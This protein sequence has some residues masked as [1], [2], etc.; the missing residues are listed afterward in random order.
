VS[1]VRSLKVTLLRVVG[2]GAGAR[3]VEEKKSWKGFASKVPKAILVMVVVMFVV[4]GMRYLGWFRGFENSHLDALIRLWAA[5]K[6]S[7]NIAI[8]EINEQDYQ[9]RF[10]GTSPLDRRKL[11]DLIRAVQKY[12]PSVIGVDIDTNGWSTACKRHYGEDGSRCAREDADFGHA[13]G[14]LRAEA[15]KNGTVIVWA[16]V[17]RTPHPPLEL[18]PGLGSLPLDPDSDQLGIPGFPV[19]EDGSVRHFDGRVEVEKSDHGCPEGADADGG[20]CYLSSFARAI[21]EACAHKSTCGHNIGKTKTSVD[22]PVIFNFHGDRYQFPIIDATQFPE[23]VPNE[24]PAEQEIDSANTELETSRNARFAGKV[25]LIGGGYPEARDEYFT[26]RGLMQG[27]ELNALAIQTDLEGGGIPEVT[28]LWEILIDFAVGLYIVGIFYRFE[29]RPW[30]ALGWTAV[31]VPIAFVASMVLFRTPAY[32]FNFI[33]VAAG[34]FLHQL[35]ELAQT[36]T[37]AQEKLRELRREQERVEVEVATV[38]QLAVAEIAEAGPADP[39]AENAKAKR[40]A[41]G[42]D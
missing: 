15:K 3:K 24:T 6:I 16:A 19:D 37:E 27:V 38:E 30:K 21:Y 26:P 34:V 8:V 40:A 10:E 25:V 18:N 42:A 23:Q 12:K 41:G 39:I 9:Q 33:P 20:K 29:A 1:I 7:K 36:G 11:L 31:V 5:P 13:L 32:W 17:P 35:W 14:E 4:Y 2:G 22:E 28:W